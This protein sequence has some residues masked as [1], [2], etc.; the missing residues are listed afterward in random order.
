MMTRR[1][2]S[3][4]IRDVARQADVS[5]ATVSRFINRNAPVSQTVAR[6][7]QEVMA[8]LNYVPHATARHLATRRTR[9]IGL[10]LINMHRDFFAPLITGIETVVDQ[11]EYSLLVAT[12]RGGQRKNQ[13]APVGTHNTDGLLVFA[14]SLSDDQIIQLY[15]RN[16]PV[17]LIHRT[18]PQNAPFPCVTVENKA[19]TRKSIEHLIEHHNRRRILFMR[20][21]LHQEDAHWREVGYKTALA[22]HGIPFDENMVLQGD[23]EREVAYASLS[24]FLRNGHPQFDAVFAGDDDAAIGVLTALKEAGLRV[25]EDVSVVGFDDLRL[26]PFL[27]PPLT[28]VRAPTEEV[29]RAAAEQLF[30]LIEHRDTESMI[31]LPTEIVYRRSCGCDYSPDLL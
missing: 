9:T 21:P 6:R 4:T 12:I 14:D 20:G 17:V 26:T 18:A 13:P 1:S 16:F 8:A 7:I 29:G 11:R 5:V 27:S 19:A 22:A 30:H 3:V 10:L 2:S 15:Q 25:P 28:T 23:F 24:H 31:L